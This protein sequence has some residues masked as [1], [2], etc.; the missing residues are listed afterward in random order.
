MVKPK[1]HLGQ[2]FLTDLSIAERIVNQVQQHNGYKTIVEIGAGTGVLTDFLVKS[3]N[4]QT[5]IIEIDTE[6][7]E[8]LHKHYP[9]LVPYI[10]EGDF[11]N[12]DLG[13]LFKQQPIG[14]IGNFPYNISS[15]IFFK[16]LDHRDQVQEV[17]CMLQKEVAER[18]AAQPGSKTYGILSVL[19][20]AYYNISY[21]FTVP[22]DVFNPPPKVY[23]GVISLQRNKVKKLD[24][25]EKLF[26][27]IVKQGF[28]NRRKTL[29]NALKSIQL[30]D[31]LKTNEMLSKRA[32]QL[33]VDN[34]VELTQLWE[35]TL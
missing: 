25:D 17:V 18:I 23:S 7:V 19:L 5:H 24:C 4:F 6:S 3:D 31:T 28:N 2:H 13:A 32:E 10:T 35:A 16:V 22:P 34:F 9:T 29:R 12:I 27:R 30:P 11:L 8:Y 33:S 21:D 1:K 26:K 15:Q 14:I 20:Q